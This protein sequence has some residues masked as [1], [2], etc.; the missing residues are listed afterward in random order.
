MSPFPENPVGA[1]HLTVKAKT[2]KMAGKA[3]HGLCCCRIPTTWLLSP[4]NTLASLRSTQPQTSHPWALVL[5][6]PLAWTALP[7]GT[8]PLPCFPVQQYILVCTV[9]HPERTANPS[10]A[11]RHIPITSTLYAV[12]AY[13]WCSIRSAAVSG[14]QTSCTGSCSPIFA[15]VLSLD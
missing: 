14:L 2:L 8:M 3:L 12:P 9:H 15:Q 6:V 11:E 13:S 10:R 1:L 5:A 7:Q 4:P